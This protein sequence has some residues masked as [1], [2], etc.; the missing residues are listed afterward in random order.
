M[1]VHVYAGWLGPEE[2]I[3]YTVSR[4]ASSVYTSIYSCG[5]GGVKLTCKSHKAIRCVYPHVSFHDAMFL[6]LLVDDLA[7]SCLHEVTARNNLDLLDLLPPDLLVGCHP[8][9]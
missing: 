9:A 8:V 5:G 3:V 7:K 6:T 1:G 4:L 2:F